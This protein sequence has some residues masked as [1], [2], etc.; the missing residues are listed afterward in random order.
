MAVRLDDVHPVRGRHYRAYYLG[1][2]IRCANRISKTDR[3]G[4]W[5]FPVPVH[6]IPQ[7]FTYRLQRVVVL[8]WIVR[9]ILDAGVCYLAPEEGVIIR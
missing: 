1:Y 7:M 2:I 9:D 4:V 6:G 3:E 5:Y 8:A